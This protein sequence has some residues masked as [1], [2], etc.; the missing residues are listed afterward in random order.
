M[1]RIHLFY[2]PIIFVFY[3]CGGGNDQEDTAE[4]DTHLK[5]YLLEMKSGAK[6]RKVFASISG[7][8]E[9]EGV[10]LS[11]EQIELGKLLYYDTRLSKDGNQSCNSCHNLSTFGVDNLP[12]SP[13]D[14]GEN[15]DRNSPTV[16]NAASHFAQFWD[17]RATTVEE[18]AGMP[19]TN[20]AEMAIPSEEF[21]EKR[22]SEIDLYKEKFAS[23][24]PE[25]KNP[26]SYENIRNSIA[27]FE[28]TLTTPS[29][30]DEYID[31]DKSAFSNEEKDGLALFMETGCTTC[32]I[33]ENLGGTMFQKFGVYADYWEFTKSKSIDEGRFKVTQ[34][35]SDK[36][37]FKVPSLRNIEKTG[38]YFHDG[39]VNDLG[40]AVRIMAKVNLDKGLTDSQ[41]ASIVTFLN[42][43][44]GG[45]PEGA[46]KMPEELN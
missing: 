17:G 27:A 16:L 18:Q 15:G 21:L 4:E 38:P 9:I 34:N 30:F 29:K 31:G 46:D 40:E 1:K 22:L 43:L 10:K 35:E 8:M 32:H 45:L 42:T 6:A 37:Y 5:E 39:S 44:T 33:G 28:R 20:P 24:F 19:I 23:V 12:T 2:L 11:K 36:Y 25:Q 3:S 41:V 14:A 13:G 7:N 26:I